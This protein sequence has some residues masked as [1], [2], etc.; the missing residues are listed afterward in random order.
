MIDPVLIDKVLARA[1][2]GRQQALADFI[3]EVSIPSIGT[4]T[5]NRDDCRRNAQWLLD[6]FQGMGM[7]AHFVEGDGHMTVEAQWMGRAG[8]KLLT[9]YGHY[10][11]QPADP[12]EDWK[13]PPFEP[14]VR[15]G[16]LFGRGASDNKGNHLACLKAMEYWMAAGG[17]PVNVRFLIEGEE[18]GGGPVL[19][20]LLA[21]EGA[22]LKSDYTLIADGTLLQ[23]L[24]G[25]RG[26]LYTEIEVTG[27][28]I[29]LHSGGFGGLVPNPF[30][31]LA[32]I[33]AALKD[34]QGRVGIPHF[35]DDVRPPSKAELESWQDFPISEAL[36]LHITGAA[37]LEGELQYSLPERGW[38]RPTLDVHGIMGGFTG[39]GT[40]TVIPTRA[41]AKVSMRLVPDQDPERILEDLRTFVAELATPGTRTRVIALG[42]GG[43][44][45]LLLDSSHPGIGAATRA[46]EK[47]FGKSP[48]LVR[49]GYS[50]PV[51]ADFA[52]HVE[53]NLFVTGFGTEEDGAHSPNERLALENFHLGTE[54]VI[55]LMQELAQT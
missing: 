8:A 41:T 4:L 42:E 33:L 39:E 1:R 29:D 44:R 46:F 40:K 14:E 50:I 55:H 47:S 38:A 20:G 37:A 5:E 48:R 43:G 22:R 27:P 3:E 21:R 15:D 26:T 52:R 36:I 16:F 32:H 7:D 31:T 2:T 53:T 30:N 24:T 23:L 45:G 11:V 25:L 17:P 18:E 49:A 13:S 19:P 9:I 12:L 6:R 10:D 51:V 28:A 35:Y 34:R 54:M